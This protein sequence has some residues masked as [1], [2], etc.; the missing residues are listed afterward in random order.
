MK[1]TVPISKN[2]P[3]QSVPKSVK[4]LKDTSSYCQIKK[5]ILIN[6]DT[7]RNHTTNENDNEKR[8]GIAGFLNITVFLRC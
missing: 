8:P 3:V 5:I 2:N 1:L 7:I 6:S 4:A